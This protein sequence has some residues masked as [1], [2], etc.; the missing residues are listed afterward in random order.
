[1]ILRRFR[2]ICPF[3]L[4]YLTYWYTI[5][6]G[7]P[8]SS[9]YFC[10][11]SNNEKGKPSFISGFNT[12]SLP[13][14]LVKLAKDLSILLIFSKN[15]L[16]MSSILPIVYLFSISFVPTLIFIISCRL[17]ALD[18][19]CFSFSSHLRWKIWW[20]IWDFSYFLM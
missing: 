13:F 18:L 5:V 7:I 6:N 9:F 11:V 3:Q 20:L 14:V 4:G 16:F 15:H 1:V 2:G 12:L 8:L 19:L 17:L 10:E